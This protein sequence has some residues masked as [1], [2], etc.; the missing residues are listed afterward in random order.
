MAALFG[1][2]S[3]LFCASGT[4]S[5]Q[6]AIATH[7][8]HGD[9]VISEREAH[10]YIYEG[11]GI[12]FNAGCQVITIAGDRG[13]IRAEQVLKILIPMTYIKREPPGLPGKHIQS[14]GRELL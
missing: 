12:A 4:M 5:N 13:R 3:A 11:G 14:R 8:K 7:T 1:M 6:V 10:V 2:E 9:E